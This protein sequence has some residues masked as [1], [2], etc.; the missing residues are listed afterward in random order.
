MT[1]QIRLDSA[2]SRL[3]LLWAGLG[4]YVAPYA[5]P[6]IVSFSLLGRVLDHLPQLGLPL[7]LYSLLTSLHPSQCDR[8]RAGWA[9]TGCMI[10]WHVWMA[11]RTDPEDM[12][13]LVTYFDPFGYT[14]YLFPLLLLIP[15]TPL[16]CSC[17]T[18]GRWL[19]VLGIPLM[20]MTLVWYASFSAIQFTF[21]G[22]VAFAGLMLMTCR[23]HSRNWVWMSALALLTALL[24]VTVKARRNL[25]MTTALYLMGG[26][27]ML[28]FYKQKMTRERRI[29]IVLCAI[30]V[31]L[32]GAGLFVIGSKGMFAEISSRANE[33]TRAY[34]F[35]LFFWDM[36]QTP[37]DC[38]IG[39]GIR[40]MYEC[41]GIDDGGSELRSAV[42]NGILNMML[43]GGIIYVVLYLTTLVTAIRKAWHCQNQICRAATFII[44]VQL[45]DQIAFGLHSVSIKAFIIWM[46]VSLCLCPG[47]CEKTD[48]E[49][50]DM[51]YEK[52]PKLPKWK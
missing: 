17:L 6:D 48:D 12:L 10:A 39:R 5:M 43:K 33:N 50:R 35:L 51:L 18:V 2:A 21:E 15:V 47:I 40:G 34:V 31:L 37:L 9:L 4:L 11:L 36:L 3:C 1:R 26:L 46:C 16:L 24:V 27:Y 45:F 28:L 38:L 8:T 49:M 13:A 41:P 22:Y 7:I 42:E 25:M 19:M 44:G 29:F 23:Y 14:L 20:L 30:S 52:R 32:V